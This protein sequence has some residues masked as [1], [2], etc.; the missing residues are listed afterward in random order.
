MA[1]FTQLLHVNGFAHND[2]N[3]RNILVSYDA[4]SVTTPLV[5]FFDCPSGRFW[6]SP[7]LE[8]RI[9]KDL[10]HL[11]K[12]ARNCLP[13]RWRLWFYKQYTGRSKL[14]SQDKRRLEKI[15]AYFER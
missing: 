15:A 3:W 5:Y 11:D 4:L 12:V 7:F 14:T 2:L 6:Q 1:H 9:V 10:A 8:Y 13:L